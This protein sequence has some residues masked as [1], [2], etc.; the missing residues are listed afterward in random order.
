MDED[1][2]AEVI[3]E[4]LDSELD[5]EA[6]EEGEIEEREGEPSAAL[7]SDDSGDGEEEETVITIGEASPTSTER[8]QAPEW[9]REL[10]SA[11]RETAKENRQLKARLAEIEAAGKKPEPIGPKPT[12]E[13]VDYDEERFERELTAWHDRKREADREIEARKAE[14]K[15]QQDE[16][17]AKLDGYA[18]KKASLRLPDFDDAEASVMKSLSVTQQG[19]LVHG[20]TDPAAL[21]Y[22]IGTN[23]E[24]LAK[25]KS[26]NDPVRFA[27]E[28][29]KLEKDMKVTTRK[30]SAPAPTNSAAGAAP[31]G[32]ANAALKQLEAEAEKT[33]DLTKLL[34]YKRKLKANA[35]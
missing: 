5:I 20:A 28:A 9:V 10:R 21:V 33:G 8:E 27:F 2:Q 13:S 32:G 23:P 30:R 6:E 12:L 19:V 1:K 25:L 3:D 17:Q 24:V 26:I 7:E 18:E 34:A 14:Q 35:R 31:I 22:A 15:R 11:H 16:Y 29:G 4:E